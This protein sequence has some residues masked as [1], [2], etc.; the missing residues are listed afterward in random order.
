MFSLQLCIPLLDNDGLQNGVLLLLQLVYLALGVHHSPLRGVRQ[1]LDLGC[2]IQRLRN[3]TLHFLGLLEM[4]ICG[5]NALLQLL[6]VL[7]C[8][9]LCQGVVIGKLAPELARRGLQEGSLVVHVCTDFLCGLI[10]QMT[11]FP[12]Q[13]LGTVGRLRILRSWRRRLRCGVCVY[14]RFVELA[15]REDALA[16][17]TATGIPARV[18]VASTS[19]RVGQRVELEQRQFDVL[20]TS[21][22][23]TAPLAVTRCTAT[24]A[25]TAAA[26]PRSRLCVARVWQWG[27]KL[28]GRFARRRRADRVL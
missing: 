4:H 1:L 7:P 5:S 24:A 25:C 6:R 18:A 10:E 3:I 22:L 8:S 16:L 14:A 2:S 28:G 27:G 20:R 13:G 26:R 9:A 21:P 17:V 19:A 11:N 15:L 12:T 23:R